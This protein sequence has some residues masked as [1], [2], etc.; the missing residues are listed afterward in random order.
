MCSASLGSTIQLWSHNPSGKAGEKG[1]GLMAEAMQ[2]KNLDTSPDET[3]SFDHG[4]MKTATV[5]AFK[6]ARELLEP[7]WKW[8]E[9]IKPIAGTDSC[10]LE[11]NGLLFSGRL[12]VVADDGS[13]MEIGPGDA[14]FVPPGHDAWVVGDEPATGVEFSREAVEK[15][16]K[17]ET[18]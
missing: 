18:G 7:G 14:Y 10:Q 11:H 17:E 15:F 3:R 1:G 2:K 9:H 6:V 13:E 8:S 16:A 5:G 12:K 4:E